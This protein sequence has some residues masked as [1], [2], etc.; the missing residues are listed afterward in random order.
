MSRQKFTVAI[1]NDEGGIELYPM[2]GWLRK[3]PEKMPPG[4]DPDPSYSTSRQLFAGLKKMGWSF[5]EFEDEIRLFPQGTPVQT[6]EEDDDESEAYFALE[7]Q[8]QEF[9]A[10]NL[11]RISINGMKLKLFKDQA[12]QL[13]KE[14]RTSDG[15]RID[16]LAVED[17]GNFVV[18]ELKKGRSPYNAIGQ[19][20][21]YMGWV[22]ETVGKGKKVRGVIVAREIDDTLRY[23]IR[24]VPDISLFEYEIDFKLKQVKGLDEK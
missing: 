9:I 20:A 21:S 8:L 13:G 6:L 19:L 11:E 18:F 4:L 17:N 3:H 10:T 12:G 5:Q 16:I 22:M 24:A 1:P 14:Y 7:S 15:K 23:S 2:K